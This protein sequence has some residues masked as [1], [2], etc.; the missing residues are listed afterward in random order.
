MTRISVL[1][2][3]FLIG[4]L[5]N[6]SLFITCASTTTWGYVGNSVHPICLIVL[7]LTKIRGLGKLII[8]V[9]TPEDP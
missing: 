3:L 9:F 7:S 1:D 6:R 2:T 5:A 8:R 4:I